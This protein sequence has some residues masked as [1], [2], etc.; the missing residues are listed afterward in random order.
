[1]PK[2][3]FSVSIED[4]LWSQLSLQS[5]VVVKVWFAYGDNMPD[6]SKEWFFG[7]EKGEVARRTS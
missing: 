4:E 3:F 7:I 6:M 5:L 2:V 1:M